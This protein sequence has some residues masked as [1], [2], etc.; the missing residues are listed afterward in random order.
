ML[1]K[2]IAFVFLLVFLTWA[3]K[4][5]PAGDKQGSSLC[6]PVPTDSDNDLLKVA[7]FNI[8]TGKSNSG[9]R[10]VNASAVVL[11]EVDLAGVQEVYAPSLLNLLGLGKQQT[12]ALAD[13]GGFSWLF[14][15]T[16]RRWLREHRGNAILSRLPVLKWHT[17]MLP[18]Q[19]GKSYRNMTV[20]EFQ[21]QGRSFHFINTHLHTRQGRAEQFEIVMQEFAKYPCAILVGDFNSNIAMPEVTRA[22]KDIAIT[23]AIEGAG[24]DLNNA[25]RIDWI[26]TKGFS[27]NSG[28]VIEKGVSDHP[29]YEVSLRFEP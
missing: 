12:Q 7:T 2:L 24:L 27:V 13:R 5:S 19:S 1:V 15:A 26:F 3:R 28:R 18:D 14:N 4:A 25:N 9:Q 16:R 22:L 29:Y 23:D 6:G 11:Q 10:D 17:K 20:A 8:Q 21:W